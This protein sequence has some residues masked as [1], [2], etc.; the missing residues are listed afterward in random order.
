MGAR[1]NTEIVESAY[2]AMNRRD[3]RAFLAVI[4][5]DVEWRAS[6]RGTDPDTYIG[7]AGVDRF[8]DTRLDV[9]DEL[10]QEPGE[11]VESG[12]KVVAV[13]DVRAK[14]RGSGIEVSERAFHLWELRDGRVVRFETFDDE[15]SLRAAAGVPDSS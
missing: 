5:R 12:E 3:M 14:G 4:D 11:M 8:L 13:V 1:A 6:N 9:W 7:Q 15:T 2:D 10:V